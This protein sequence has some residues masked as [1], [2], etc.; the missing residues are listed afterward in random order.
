MNLSILPVDTQPNQTFEC[1]L[2][3]DDKNRRFKF[4]FSWNAIGQYWQFDLYDQNQDNIQ[5]LSNQVVCPI[6]APYN[7]IL[8]SYTYKEIG[9]LYV[10]NVSDVSGDRPGLQNLGSDWLLVW[11][12]TPSV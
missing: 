10:I 6:N 3:V 7:N 5:L 8:W 1:S 12:D 4:F 2:P 9:S 11:G